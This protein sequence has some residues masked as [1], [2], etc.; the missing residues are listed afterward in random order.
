MGLDMYGYAT[1]FDN[2]KDSEEQ[3]K[4]LKTDYKSEKI[5]DR[6]QIGDWRKHNRLHGYMEEL[7]HD[8][9]CP[10]VPL[11][12]DGEPIMEQGFGSSF[13]LI[14]LLLEKKDLKDLKQSITKKTLPETGGFFFGSDSYSDDEWGK[15]QKEEDLLALKE[16]ILK[17]ALPETQGFFFGHDSYD[18]RKDEIDEETKYDLKFVDKGIKAIKDGYTVI[19]NSWW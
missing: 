15:Q 6:E 4:I 7:W 1:K 14:P 13:N 2:I 19:Y 9:G 5:L 16:D 11:D 17:R 12:E 3:I 10:G 18:W 8:K